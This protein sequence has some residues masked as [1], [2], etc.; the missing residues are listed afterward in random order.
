MLDKGEVFISC[1][2]RENG[3]MIRIVNYVPGAETAHIATH[4]SDTRIRRIKVSELHDE[5]IT[6]QGNPRLTGYVRMRGERVQG[7]GA[8]AFGPSVSA[9]M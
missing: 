1:N 2:P 9:T 5:A 3:R 7:N 4:P 8:N 6:Q